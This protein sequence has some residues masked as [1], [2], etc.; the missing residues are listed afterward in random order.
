[1]RKLVSFIAVFFVTLFVW[2]STPNVIVEHYTVEQGLPNNVVNC[3]LKDKDGFIWFGTW[4]GLCR[5]DGQKFY[6]YNKQQSPDS[7]LPPRKIQHIVEDKNQNLWLKTID[8]KLFVFDKQT[9][10]FHAV[11]D[12]MKNYSDNIQV[13]KM[14]T[15]ASGEVLLLT[16]DRNLLL[17][18]VNANGEINI[19]VLY[20]SKKEYN[21]NAYRLKHSVIQETKDYIC[22]IGIDDKIAAIKKSE[23]LADNTD[24]MITTKLQLTDERYLTCM[25]EDGQYLWLGDNIG[26]FSCIDP[27]TG[28]VDR[29]V[30]PELKGQIQN[31]L[32]VEDKQIY[33]TLT[34]KGT[35]LYDLNNRELKKIHLPITDGYI[36]ESMV[37]RCGMIWF[38]ENGKSLICYDVLTDKAERYPYRNGTQ[39]GYGI[40]Y[41]EESKDDGLFFLTPVGEALYFDRKEHK[42]LQVE[43]FKQ[44]NPHGRTRINFFNLF[45]DRDGIL[46]LAST[47]NGIYRIEFPK[48]QFD[49]VD[50]PFVNRNDKN[51]VYGVRALYQTKDGDIWIST[52]KP[53]LYRY[54]KNKNLKHI[55]GN[56]N[57]K[58]GVVYHIMED[59]QGNIWL[60]T[61]G[62]GLIKAVPDND[63][64]KGYRFIHYEHNP[65]DIYSLNGKNVYYTY[66]D[67]KGRIW[68]AVLDGGLNLL[69]E[70]DGR[71]VFHHRNNSFKNY[72]LY[73]LYT[74]VRN[75]LEDEDGRIWVGTM[76]GLM[77]FDVNFVS[78]DQIKFATYR[79]ENR[80]GIADSD[81]YVL[82]K[83]KEQNVWACVF[84]GGVHKIVE[85]DH[86]NHSLKFE[87]YGTDEGLGDDVIVSMIE[88]NDSCIWLVSENGIASL[89]KKT[90]RIR[91]FDE[92]DGLP[93]ISVE[94]GV[95]MKTEDGDIWIGCRHGILLLS[96]DKLIPNQM[97]Y[98][99]FIVDCQVNNMNFR[100]LDINDIS[101]K[102]ITYSEGIELEY[103][104]SMFTIE[105]AA[106]NYTNHKRVS[107]K[108]ILEGYEKEWHNNGHNRIAAYTNVPSGDYVFKV[109]AFD[110][111]NPSLDSV[112][113]LKIKILPPWWATKWAY[114]IYFLL[115]IGLLIMV[116]KIALLMMRM[117][118]D[119]YIGQRLSE[120]KI[121]FFT[122]ISHELRTPLTLIQGPIQELKANENLSDKG[123]QYID[124]MEK[125][126]IQMLQLVNQ[127]LDFR[128]IQNGK[129]RL[130][131]SRFNL[132]EM[133]QGFGHE[134]RILAEENSI[135]F[136]VEET[137]LQ[138][139]VWADSEKLSM[140]IRNILS[141]AF[142]FTPSGGRISVKASISPDKSR[143]YIHIK[144]TGVGIPQSQLSEIFERFSQAEN[145]KAAS[146]YQGTGIGLALSKEIMNLHH[147]E[148]YAESQEEK[149]ACFVVELLM[150]KAHYKESEVDFYVGEDILMEE[151]V[152]EEQEEDDPI[153]DSSLPSVLIVDDNKDLC[154]M[155]RMQLEDSYNIYMANDGVEGLKKIA[156]YHPDVV[157]T[158]QMMPNMDGLEMLQ[159]I[160]KDFQISHIPV[161]I[162]TA[163]GNDDSRTEAISKGANAYITKPFSKEYLMARIEQLL[164]ERKLFREHVW[165]SE[166]QIPVVQDEYA[167]YLVTKDVQ[168]IE[169]IHQIVEENMDNSEFN[170]DT[171]ASNIGLS[172]SAFFKKLKSL[173]GFAPVDLVK[174]IRLN[175]SVELMKNSDMSISE[176]AFAVGFRDAGYFGKCFRKKYNQTPREYMNECRRI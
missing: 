135:K 7:E 109:Q 41:M 94:E 78:P 155:L 11:Y 46:W 101:R 60:S 173:T 156:L 75:I 62:D 83:D 110:E 59:N 25:Y 169:K 56:G 70:K 98:N 87:S 58:L 49:L 4:Y 175:K 33:I 154:N 88:D 18:E 137:N 174:E 157:V 32:A 165:Q 134:F 52:R 123:K 76:D 54:D 64:S 138:I 8:H 16:L 65:S 93:E 69:E 129:M 28:A 130:H 114:L 24:N 163:K 29:Y 66:Q 42:M 164:N 162:L 43:S 149:G 5:F 23:F 47:D 51:E 170:I 84:G 55:Y 161:I 57:E 14:Q 45:Q 103:D 61:K 71:I 3:T 95:V 37:D 160:R 126:I 21:A 111:S 73:G 19:R 63:E 35:Y 106:L 15:N 167:Q 172:R 50:I 100:Q 139:K 9:E 74:E 12:D 168:F 107:Y 68:A 17:A 92:Y 144:D 39:L 85:S 116:V 34:G 104:Q 146:Y 30:L 27:Q 36:S 6:T 79:I 22:W 147:G 40:L 151:S 119:V 90:G 115:L 176:I 108:Y 158:D 166:K 150:G 122:N 105:F 132:N 120:L 133:L 53:E 80:A 131:V 99:T 127:I 113:K 1:M 10:L 128:K 38:H 89:D 72:P 171:I 148:I 67:S 112:R 31:L 143:C 125:N 141:N 117:K 136:I 140:V 13:V 44:L 77:S 97:S 86:L 81:V 82:Y 20:D 2:S 96:P 102:S 118:N 159:H 145:V 142:K 152:S 26:V 121:K 48:N 124:L 153:V 91:N